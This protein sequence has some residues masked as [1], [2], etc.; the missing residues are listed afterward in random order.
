MN[1][2]R[3]LFIV[4]CMIIMLPACDDDESVNYNL[5]GTWSGPYNGVSGSGTITSILGQTGNQVTGTYMTVDDTGTVAGTVDGK[6]FEA[7]VT[8]TIYTCESYLHFTIQ[9]SMH[10]G[11]YYAGYDACADSGSI[12][13]TKQ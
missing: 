11:G 9:D 6:R 3:F 1:I 2:Q 4:L 8:S 10:I 5:T 12:S 13:M 7:T